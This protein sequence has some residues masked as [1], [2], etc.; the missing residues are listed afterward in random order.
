MN[1]Q[2]RCTFSSIAA[3][4]VLAA[5]VMVLPVVRACAGNIYVDRTAT[6]ANNGTS[7][8]N[9]HTD[10]QSALSA[11]ISGDTI[12]VAQGTYKPTTSTYNNV[13][14]QL[15]NGVT[16]LGGYPTGGGTRNPA[17]NTTTL[18][19]DLLGNDNSNV[20]WDE[21]TRSDNSFNVVTG[22]GTDNTAVMDGFTVTG[23]DARGTTGGGG[24]FNSGGGPPC[25]TSPSAATRPSGVAAQYATPG[26]SAS[27]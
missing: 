23:G 13:T 5:L 9:A 22:S 7:W 10:L 8:A 12:H 14:F 1:R 21:P 25:K 15:K 24:M 4:L 2:V 17:T 27:F 26:Q 6:G 19:G 3:K 11:A 20:K 18:S 16:L